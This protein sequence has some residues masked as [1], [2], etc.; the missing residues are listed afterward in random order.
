MRNTGLDYLPEKISLAENVAVSDKALVL[1]GLV[2][3]RALQALRVP[4]LVEDAEDEPV[5]DHHPAPGAFR[6]R[7]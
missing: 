3:V 7:R 6:D 5:Q 1:E 2:A 4:V